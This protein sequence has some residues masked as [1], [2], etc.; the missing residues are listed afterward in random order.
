[1]ELQ[2][3]PWDYLSVS[4]AIDI[5]HPVVLSTAAR[6]QAGDD[7]GYT[8]EAFEFVRDR[9]AHSM[10]AGDDRVTWRAS[11]V[12]EQRTGLCFAK[13]HAF[14]A[15]LRAGGVPAGFCYQRL[16]DDGPG[17]GGGHVLHGLAAVQLGD[18]W[19]RLDPR[20]NRPGLQVGFSATEDRLAFPVRPELGEIDYPVIFARPHPIVLA[21]LR[22]E[23][24]CRVLCAG[25]LPAELPDQ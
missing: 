19:V 20:G 15:L 17:G 14:V 6:F 9:I 2:A 18:R 21:A 7:E 16:S 24:D 4:E 8:R 12:I 22:A 10:D 3:E 23:K 11:D 25:G 5:E 13:S 1:M